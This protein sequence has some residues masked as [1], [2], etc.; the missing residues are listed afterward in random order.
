VDLP[1]SDFALLPGMYV[2]VAF[3]LKSANFVQVP[4]S[5]M[6]FRSGGPQVAL[7]S[8]DGTVKF[9]DVTIARDNGNFVE[10][11]SGLTAGD[12]V[13]LNISNQIANGDRVAV[14]Q[15]ARTAEAR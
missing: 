7:I 2:Q 10:I 13:A 12:R 3:Q 1:N 4:A 11:A 14:R 15:E 9:R 6:I 8:G 5:A